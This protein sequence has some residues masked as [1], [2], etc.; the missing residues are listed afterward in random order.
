MKLFEA[1]SLQVCPISGL[2]GSLLAQRWKELMD[3]GWDGDGAKSEKQVPTEAPLTS[4][5][6]KF[7]SATFRRQILESR[8]FSLILDMAVKQRPQNKECSG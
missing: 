6:V 1:H 5:T 3:S 4:V 8:M 2:R 7:R